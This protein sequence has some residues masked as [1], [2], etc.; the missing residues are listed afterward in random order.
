MQ[1][2]VCVA[3]NVVGKEPMLRSRIRLHKRIT[4]MA[5]ALFGLVVCL[6]CLMILTNV[7][8]E[9]MLFVGQV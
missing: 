6:F 8:D 2:V 1:G 4:A 9:N 5:H 7:I 3:K